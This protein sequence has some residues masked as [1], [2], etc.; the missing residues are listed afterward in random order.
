MTGSSTKLATDTRTAGP[1]DQEQQSAKYRL[2][3]GG[4]ITAGALVLLS[5]KLWLQTLDPSLKLDDALSVGLVIV[6]VLPWISELL[7]GAKLPGGVEVIFRDI[8]EN[9]AKQEALLIQQQ[10]QIAALRTAVRCIVTKYEHEKLMGLSK[11]APFFCERSDDMFNELK[12]LRALDLI[13]HHEGTGIT[14]MKSD[15][16]DKSRLDLKR[17]F[18]ITGEGRNYLKIRD[19][20]NQ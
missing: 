2:L 1:A 3:V 6:A 9:Q 19:D 4:G 7:A 10:D 8:K 18:Y 16:Q 15:Y 12:R 13:N 20:W 14:Q 11:D 17:Y 5:V